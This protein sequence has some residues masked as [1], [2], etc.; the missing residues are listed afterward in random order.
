MGNC[1]ELEE[2]IEDF[3]FSMVL[4]VLGT[5]TIDINGFS[6]VFESFDHW[7][8]M[9]RDYWSNDGMVSMDRSGLFQIKTRMSWD[10]GMLPHLINVAF[11]C[12]LLGL[13]ALR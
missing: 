11:V 10:V 5:L 7:F 12:L 4:E 9:V 8:S 3:Q 13:F 2:T 6:M 1:N